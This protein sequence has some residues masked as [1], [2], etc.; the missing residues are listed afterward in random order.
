MK[1][2]ALAVSVVVLLNLVIPSMAFALSWTRTGGNGTFNDPNW[3]CRGTQGYLK[4]YSDKPSNCH[5]QSILHYWKTSLP[6]RQFVET[7]WVWA[8]SWSKAKAFWAR[9]IN[10][11]DYSDGYLGNCEPGSTNL[12]TLHYEGRNPSNTAEVWGIYIN[13]ILSIQIDHPSLRDAYSMCDCERQ[14]SSESNYGRFPG[15]TGGRMEVFSNIGGYWHWIEYTQPQ[16]W[17]EVEGTDG[18]YQFYPYYQGQPSQ[19][20]CECK[21]KYLPDQP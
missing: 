8:N 21:K 11:Y 19:N 20:W 10:H 1:R 4:T 13:G 9:V 17:W 12:F 15:V 3:R 14:S 6:D 2:K 5:V 16:D 18:G 7:G